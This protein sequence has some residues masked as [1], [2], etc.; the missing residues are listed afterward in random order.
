MLKRSAVNNDEAAKV[1]T[2]A[3]ESFDQAIVLHISSALTTSR[4]AAKVVVVGV[5]H[6]YWGE[7]L[8]LKL[9]GPQ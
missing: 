5:L 4:C 8:R 3:R 6:M 9:T 2:Q 7:L 1:E